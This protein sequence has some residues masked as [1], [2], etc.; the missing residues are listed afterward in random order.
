MR[1]EKL[2]PMD[3][4]QVAADAKGVSTDDWLM[5]AIKSALVRQKVLPATKKTGKGCKG[6]ANNRLLNAKKLCAEQKIRPTASRLAQL[7]ATNYKTAQAFLALDIHP[8]LKARDS[9]SCD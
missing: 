9:Q 5:S 4:I 7:A 8:R 6:S 3:L 1:L 2:L